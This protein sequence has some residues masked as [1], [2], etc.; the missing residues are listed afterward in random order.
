MDIYTF[1]FDI[2]NCTFTFNSYQHSDAFFSLCLALMVA[3]LLETILIINIQCGSTHYGHLPQW[4]KVLFLNYVAKLVRLSKK[5][6]DQNCDLEEHRVETKR[7]DPEAETSL[8]EAAHKTPALLELKKI[9]HKLLSIH[10][11]LDK[12]LKT[13]ESTDEWV[14][15]GRVIDRLLFC[16]YIVFLSVA[17]FTALLSQ[18]QLIIY[19]LI[20][21][22]LLMKSAETINCSEPTSDALLVALKDSIFDKTDVRPVFYQKTPTKIND[23]K[24]QIFDSFIWMYL[25]W[26]IEGLSWD[27]DECGT[28]RIS[29]PRKQL[30][31]PDIVI[32]EFMDENKSPDTYY[33]Y[34]Q[35]T[36]VVM[37]D[38]PIHVISSCNMDIYTFP[39]DIQNCTLTFNSYKLTA[40]DVQ[41]LFVEPVEVI[42]SRRP[43]MY[44]VNLLIPSCFLIT[45]D[46]FS[47]LLPPQNVDRSAF[48]MTLIFGYTVFLLLMNDLLPVT[49]NN[50]P[51]ISLYRSFVVAFH[52]LNQPYAFFSLCFAL[53]VASLLETIFIT[54]IQCGSIHYG[55]LP[56]WAKVVFL[57]FVARLVC[58]SKKPSDQNCVPEEHRTEAKRCNPAVETPQSE[59]VHKTPALLELKKISHVLLSIRQQVEKH[60]KTDESTEEFKCSLCRRTWGSSRV[61]VVFHFQLNKARRQGTIKLRGY[62]QEC[63]TCSEAQME[64]PKFPEENIDVL[65]ERLVKKIRMRCYREKLADGCNY[66]PK[67]TGNTGTNGLKTTG[68]GSAETSG[69]GTTRLGNIKANRLETNGPGSTETN[70]LRTTGL[71]STETNGLE[72]T[73]L[74]SAETSG[75]GTTGLGSTE[76]NEL[77]TN[78]P[79]STE[80]NR[81]GITRLGSTETNGHGITNPRSTETNRLGTTRLGST[82][83]N[84]LGTNGPGITEINGLGTMGIGSTETKIFETTGP[85]STETNGLEIMMSRSTETSKLG[86][87]GPR[88]TGT[89]RLGTTRLG[90]TDTKRFQTTRPGNTE[91]NGLEMTIWKIEGLSWDPDECGTDRISIPRKKL[92]RPDIIIS[93]FIDEN[94]VPDTYYLYIE[95]TGKAT[96]DLPFHVISSCNMDIYTFPFDIQNCTFTFN[97]YQHTD[98]FFS[99]CLALMVAS[100]LETILIINI[101]CGSTH[102]GPLP[103][104]AKVLF[105]NYVAKLVRL[106]KKPSDQNCDL[107]AKEGDGCSIAL[108]TTA[109]LMKSAETINCSEPTSDALLVA[110]KDSI[111]DKTDVR[112]VFYQKTPTN[113]NVSFTLYGILGVDEKAQIFDSYIWVYL[114]WNIEGL[115]WDPDECGTDRISLPRK[116]LWMPDIVI[117]QFMDENKS[118]DTY[119]LYVQHTGVVMDDLSIH[120]I[121]SCNMDIYTFPFDIQNCSLTFNS[122]KLTARDVRLFFVE[123]VEVILSRRPTMYVVNLLIPSCFLITVDLFSFLLPPQNVDRSAFKMTL[124]FGYTVFLLLMNDLLPV[125]GNNLPLINVFF[126]LCF[127]LM[128]ASLLETIFITNIQCGSIHYGPLPRWAKVVFLNFVA[129]LVCLSKKPSDQNCVPEEHRTKG[130]RCNPA[131]QTPQS[132]A[133]HKTPA[134]LELKKISHVLLSIHQQ[135]WTIEGLSWDPVE[136]GTDRITLPR[137]KLWRPDIVINEFISDNQAP[138]T[139]YLYLYNNGKAEDR[140]PVHVISFCNLDIYTFPFDI[141]NCTYTFGSYKHTIRDVQILFGEPV[142]ATLKKSLEYMETKGEWQLTD[143]IGK[144]SVNSSYFNVN[145]LDKWDELVY[146]I[147]LK[148][149]P[150]LYVVNLLIPSYCLIT[151]DLFS[152]LLPPQNMDRSAFKMTLILGYTVFL[153]LMNDLLPVT[154]DTIPIITVFLASVESLNCSEPTT[155]ALLTAMRE[156]VIFYSDARPVISL[157]TPTNVTV[158]LTLYGILG[159]NEK[160]QVLE[161]YLWVRMR[162]QIEGLSWDAAECGTKKISLPRDKIWIPDIVINE[163]MDENRAPETYYVYVTN[164]G[165]VLDGR[166]FHVISSCRLD[167]YT[168]PFDF[169]NCTY[170]FNSYKH[171]RDDVQLFFLLPVEQIF[172]NSLEAI[173]TKGEW[174]LIDMRAEKPLL[175]F[176]DGG[177]DNLIVYVG[178]ILDLGGNSLRIADVFFSLC[179][180]LMVASLLETIFIT[181][182]LYG[183]RDLPPLPKWLRILVLKYFA[184]I[185]CMKKP[186]DRHLEG[187]NRSESI[188]YK[189]PMTDNAMTDIPKKELVGAS[190]VRVW[191]QCFDEMKKMSQ[192]L[193]AIRHQVEEHLNNDNK[194]DDWM[195]FGQV[196]DRVL[197]IMYS[198]FIVIEDTKSLMMSVGA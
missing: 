73:E 132:E 29:L 58:L 87:T 24:A 141:Q 187:E 66:V 52:C 43:T 60:L 8:S 80:T 125:T 118:P 155:K 12:H 134:L 91:T 153:L 117:N 97:S 164:T 61:Q 31:M 194:T 30:W 158:D 1:P 157:S 135:D 57:N 160:A 64:D 90:I 45:V 93:E 10:Q 100:L 20:M 53:M 102:Y 159:V 198:L 126:S 146:H 172:K 179:L 37:D 3:S 133:V 193:L 32:N 21:Q 161:T 149:R 62:K 9:S 47:F 196:I 169:Q 105:L 182:I 18:F 25:L 104:W 109:L 171:S 33:V 50:L 7:C 49:G 76:T 99:L 181:N 130:K 162:W 140:L 89:I 6:S 68:P 121:S 185:A 122:Y 129:R 27:P 152:F 28:D 65:V 168:F 170:T 54:N 166:P 137:K 189:N 51:L 127:A 84:G 191:D 69:L 136:C 101:Q 173:T 174:E 92:W 36:G 70:G 113:I 41:L 106:S 15:L 131:V 192:D 142:E 81:F 148:R 56:R 42:L 17:E 19:C 128:V 143:M 13:D 150:T 94:K 86:A 147:V 83:T 48:K 11:Q 75:L 176:L 186:C 85:G 123:P 183:S 46:L 22:S 190:S 178:G 107:E 151:V 39:F 167:I 110:L 35:Y 111:F 165:T 82:E 88:S 144:K 74:G 154:G 38:R 188:F 23:E 184:R 175:L 138:D 14:H 95:Y 67:T 156:E 139:Y 2:Q 108:K 79:G 72:T 96:D 5:P 103:Q 124:I 78:R 71:V 63:K 197:F 26:N 195:M 40:R 4:A 177:W 119:Y 34:V 98:A 115:S 59:G 120:V 112:P 180:A 114:L 145:G 16:L 77:G 55:P 44:V 116:K 163:F